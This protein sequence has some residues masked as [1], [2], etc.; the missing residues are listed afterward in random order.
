MA[1]EILSWLL[2]IWLD[3][4]QEGII[5][6]RLSDY[7]TFRLSRYDI[8]LVII[9]KEIFAQEFRYMFYN[10][11]KSKYS[12]NLNWIHPVI[13]ISFL[14]GQCQIVPVCKEICLC[15]G[16]Q[17]DRR[18]QKDNKVT[19]MKILHIM[20]WKQTTICPNDRA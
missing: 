2:L 18:L 1:L 19:V 4:V 3:I 15:I 12:L 14:P 9:M 6:L 13:S 8:L 10:N 20:L 16:L 17:K 11:I 7:H 5:I